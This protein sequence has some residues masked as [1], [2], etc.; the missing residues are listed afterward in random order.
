[1]MKITFYKTRDPYGEFSN[2]SRYPI[3]LKG[4]FWPTTEHYFQAQKYSGTPHEEDVRQAS[5]PSIAAQIGRDRARPLRPDWEL[6]KEKVMKEALITKT[7]QHPYIK[8]LLL[9]TG[10]AEIVEHTTKDSYWGDGGDGSGKN[11]LGILWMEIRDELRK[12]SN[13]KNNK[14]TD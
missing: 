3:I 12:Q 1:M 13:E 5:K 6:V 2:F 14:E 10:D 11:R 9:S 7:E 4:L 8:K